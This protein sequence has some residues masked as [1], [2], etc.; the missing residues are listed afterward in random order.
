[1]REKWAYKKQVK[2]DPS[3]RFA[4]EKE[5]EL[6][7][8]TIHSSYFQTGKRLYETR[9]LLRRRDFQSLIKKVQVFMH[10]TKLPKDPEAMNFFQNSPYYHPDIESKNVD[11][12]SKIA[13]YTCIFGDYDEPLELLYI[14]PNVDYYLITDSFLEEDMINGWTVIHLN[15]VFDDPFIANRYC[16]MHPYELFEGY[17]LAIYLDG[18]ILPVSDISRFGVCAQISKTGIAAHGHPERTC[19]YDEAKTCL[20]KQRGNPQAIKKW[21]ERLDR[22]QMPHSYG[23]LEM[24]VIYYDLHNNNMLTLAEQWWE[25][26]LESK[27]KRDQIVLPYVAWI[28]RFEMQDFGII[29]PSLRKN[30]A[31]NLAPWHISRSAYR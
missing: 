5:N 24:G 12:S 16:K 31:F 25:L 15:D 6:Y 4:L 17:D 9:Q 2:M 21:I 13:V 10:N 8:N 7:Q 27:T 22:E 29:G 3:L 19:L 14:E 30:Y 28:N 23:L 20:L 1:M 26:L 18:N 11:E